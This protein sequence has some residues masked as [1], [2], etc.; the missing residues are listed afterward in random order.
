MTR[1]LGRRQPVILVAEQELLLRFLVAEFLRTVGYDVIEVGDIG[2]VVSVFHAGTPVDLVFCEVHFCRENNL[3]VLRWLCG[4]HPD[5]RILLTSACNGAADAQTLAI[6]FIPK[7]YRMPDL[8]LRIG[9]LL[10]DDNNA[11]ESSAPAVLRV[12][13][14]QTGIT[15]TTLALTGQAASWLTCIKA[16]RSICPNRGRAHELGTEKHK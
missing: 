4:H 1:R 3:D 6:E 5:V 10:R 15:P 2:E 11:A 7:P 12:Q 9:A 14:R 16:Q 13:S 8:A